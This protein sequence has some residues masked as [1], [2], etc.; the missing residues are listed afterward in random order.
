VAKQRV[1]SLVNVGQNQPWIP[2]A[3]ATSD[4]LETRDLGDLTNGDACLVAT[5]IK[6][7]AVTVERSP[8]AVI[9]PRTDRERPRLLLQPPTD[10]LSNRYLAQDS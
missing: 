8:S 10:V 3:V 6:A 4:Q 9:P 2:P 7:K 5:K 1:Y